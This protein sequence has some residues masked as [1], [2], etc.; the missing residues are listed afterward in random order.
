MS[1]LKEMGYINVKELWY[2]VGGGT[3]LEGRL[4]LLFD[5]KGACDLLNLAILNGQSHLYV[6]NMVLDPEY[7]D[8]LEY[9]AEPEVERHNVEPEVERDQEQEADGAILGEGDN[10]NGVEAECEG[11]SDEAV[12]GEDAEGGNDNIV[13]TEADGESDGAALGEDGEVKKRRLEPWELQKD[14]T[15]LRQGGTCKR[16]DICRQLGHK[17]NTFP[18]DAPTTPNPTQSSHITQCE[19][20]QPQ[21]SQPTTTTPQP[22]TTLVDPTTR[23]ADSTATTP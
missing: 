22:T 17:R 23:Q 12:L 6:V 13:E 7:V 16:C 3:V 18:Q 19:I 1:I 4:E 9:V 5:D 20:E 14:D 11:E 15:Q 8:M 2:L 10:D 21:Q